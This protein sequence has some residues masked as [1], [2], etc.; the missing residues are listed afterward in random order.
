MLIGV[1]N[2]YVD[3]KNKDEIPLYEV[4]LD[5]QSNDLI[6]ILNDRY[7]NIKFRDQYD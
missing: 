3:K 1:V 4:L 6:T 5:M 7:S 2:E